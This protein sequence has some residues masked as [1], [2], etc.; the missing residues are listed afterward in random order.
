M[1]LQVGGVSKLEAMKH[2][3]ESRETQTRERL[4]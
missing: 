1:I 4:R 3:H 2:G